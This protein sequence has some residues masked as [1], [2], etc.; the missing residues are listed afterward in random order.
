MKNS[1]KPMMAMKKT[2]KVMPAKKGK[3]FP[4]LNKDGKVTKKDILMGRGVIGK[5]KFAYDV[6]GDAVNIASRLEHTGEVGK[7]NISGET[8]QLIKDKFNCTYRGQLTA[9]GKGDIDMY[10]VEQARIE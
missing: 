2:V 7:V 3:S 9:K 5:K 4:D 1:M 10:F 8:Y 6:W